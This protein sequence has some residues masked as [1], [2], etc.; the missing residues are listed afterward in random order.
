MHITLIRL[1]TIYY[2]ESVTLYVNTTILPSEP[3]PPILSE[4]WCL[5]VM[6]LTTLSLF[7][8]SFSI[9]HVPFGGDGL[10]RQSVQR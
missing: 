5:V 10:V 6:V 1:S 4:S 2:Y 9:I 3:Q 7:L 8:V